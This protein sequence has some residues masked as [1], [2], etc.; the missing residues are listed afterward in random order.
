MVWRCVYIC[1]NGVVRDVQ[2]IEG[3]HGPM[4][5]K[6]RRRRGRGRPNPAPHRQLPTAGPRLHVKLATA[7][8]NLGASAELAKPAIL[9]ADDV[10]IYSPGASLIKAVYDVTSITDPRKQMLALLEMAPSVPVLAS[11]L[12]QFDE[13]TLALVRQAMT[14][15]RR[16]W[17][18][19]GQATGL[20]AELAQLERKLDDMARN[21]NKQM[22]TARAQALAGVGGEQ[23]ASAME[24]GAVKVADLSDAK[25]TDLVAEALRA[26]T[27]ATSTTRSETDLLVEG[28][29]ARVVEILSEA[30]SFPLLDAQ[31][32]GLLQALE[33]EHG[34]MSEV[35][36]LAM[37]HGA[38]VASAAKFMGYLPYFT[39][40]PVDEVL[41][42]RSRMQGPLV[43]FRGAMAEMSHD[44]ES[45]PIDDAFEAEVA[46][47]WRNRV[48]PA[49]VDIREGL[50]EHGLLR[51]A[52]SIVDGDARRLMV[53]A[54]GVFVV[55][56]GALRSVSGLMTAALAV[57]L[58]L[59][60]VVGRALQNAKSGRR[61]LRKS[62]FF[63]LHRL[64]HE[65]ERRGR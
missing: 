38:E 60:D 53:E 5:K 61:E 42:L 65:S 41:D 24:S 62:P 57:G 27:G 43:R 19:L 64:A 58:P 11:E 48:A 36:D 33:R 51:E 34:P 30:S 52:G 45:R 49:L 40:L 13:A 17:N 25:A 14:L 4:P 35:S 21:W 7:G 31:T 56:Q 12:A 32:S 23:L 16:Q 47:A 46:D 63:F 29:V 26:A 28:Y 18:R 22:P 50:S 15:D 37:R 8:G 20:A 44:F 2:R 6:G 3:H 9:Y 55:A 10:T 59:V 1:T 54:G 39:D